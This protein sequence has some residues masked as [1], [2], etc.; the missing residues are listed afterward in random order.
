[1][2]EAHPEELLTG[3]GEELRG[4]RHLPLRVERPD[5]YLYEE[6]LADAD[7][8]EGERPLV[9]GNRRGDVHPGD[10]QRER[11]RRQQQ[12][13]QHDGQLLHPVPPTA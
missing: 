8:V 9:D 5:I 12:E 3:V 2:H 1:V 11:S 7:P 10:V 6:F 13:R 4:G